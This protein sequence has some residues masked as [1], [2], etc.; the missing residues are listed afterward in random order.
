VVTM[1]EGSVFPIIDLP[2]AT[3]TQIAPFRRSSRWSCL[4]ALAG[5]LIGAA[6]RASH[7][8]I[9]GVHLGVV[10]RRILVGYTGHRDLGGA[11]N[12]RPSSDLT[13]TGFA[14]K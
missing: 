12:A 7:Q 5:R 3:A 9:P 4:Y 6:M 10:L 8:P 11:H 2:P 1:N 14:P 13:E